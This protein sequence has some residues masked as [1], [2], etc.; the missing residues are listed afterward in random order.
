MINDKRMK[1]I[2]T[3]DGFDLFLYSP[4][5]FRHY[6]NKNEDWTPHRRS[7]TH[8]IHM[9]LYHI[10]GGYQILYM[11]DGDNIAAYIVFA[12]CGK[13]VIK[14]STRNDIY[15]VYVTTHPDYRMRGLAKKIVH[16]LLSGIGL[17]YDNAYKAIVDSNIGS[18]KAAF[19]NGYKVL[20][21]A[22]KSGPLKTISQSNSGDWR[23]YA[24]R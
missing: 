12:R 16:E 22:K 20:Y 1:F 8:H 13:T 9:M 19:A 10:R 15:T 5:L 24:L 3:Y 17:K 21:Q 6:Y 4:S 11:M 14:D 23:L 2:K 18:Q 7:I